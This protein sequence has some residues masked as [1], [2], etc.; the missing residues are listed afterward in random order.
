MNCLQFSCLSFRRA[1]MT[2]MHPLHLAFLS[3]MPLLD[4]PTILSGPDPQTS[5][6]AISA[7]SGFDLANALSENPLSLLLRAHSLPAL[8]PIERPSLMIQ[9]LQME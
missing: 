4:P 7:F 6:A 1:G 2:D 3:L 9:L 8:M 5:N